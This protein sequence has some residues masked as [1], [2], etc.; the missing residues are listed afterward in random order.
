MSTEWY[1]AR[2]DA[3]NEYNRQVANDECPDCEDCDQVFELEEVIANYV[4]AM[5]LLLEC[6]GSFPDEDKAM[7][8][9]K[10]AKLGF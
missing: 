3:R 6:W 9:E 7:L 8:D 4:K 5:N 2:E 10:L 1:E